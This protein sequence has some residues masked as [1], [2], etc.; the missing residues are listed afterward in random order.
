MM[1]SCIAR[2]ELYRL[3][4]FS[5]SSLKIPIETVQTR[6]MRFAEA[7]VQFQG[8]PGSGFCFGHCFLGRH[9]GIFPIAQ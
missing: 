8:F 2:V 4:E 5:V 9:H 7:A 3:P 6:G 1:S